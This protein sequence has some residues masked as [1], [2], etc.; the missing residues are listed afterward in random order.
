MQFDITDI[1]HVLL[2]QTL[3]AHSA[4]LLLGK[5]EYNILKIRGDNV[6]GLSDEECQEILS[7]FYVDTE[8]CTSILDYHKGKPMKIVFERKR[9][10]RILVESDHYDHRNG[11][12]RFFEALLD[13]FFFDEILITKKGYRE[14]SLY[15][16]P[17][18]LKR[19]KED[20]L[21]FKTLLRNTILIEEIGYK[22][23]IVDKSKCEYKS[24]YM[25]QI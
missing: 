10:G 9:N 8:P 20:L 24:N 19:T 14:F 18:D 16:M 5:A 12:Y 1:N 13:V 11:E 4:P 23:H 7:P 3:F 2:L 21:K 15:G 17:E 6:D 22:Y 25:I